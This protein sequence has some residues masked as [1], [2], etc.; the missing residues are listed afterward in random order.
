MTAGPT[1][2]TIKRKVR[3]RGEALFIRRTLLAAKSPDAHIRPLIGVTSQR[4]ADPQKAAR[5][6]P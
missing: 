4:Y 5:P 1:P 3:E 6:F 2:V